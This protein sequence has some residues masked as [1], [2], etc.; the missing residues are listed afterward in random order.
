MVTA[1]SLK[2]VKVFRNGRAQGPGALKPSSLKNVIGK[3]RK[4]LRGAALAL[5]VE[6][7]AYGV[8]KGRSEIDFWTWG[9]RKPVQRLL[10]PTMLPARVDSGDASRCLGKSREVSVR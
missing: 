10:D 1:D 2:T 8:P 7:M 9:A 4:P 5:L 6:G 3:G